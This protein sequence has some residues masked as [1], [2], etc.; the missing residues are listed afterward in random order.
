MEAVYTFSK[1]I[2]LGADY[3]N[4]AYD[5]DT[6]LSR[7]QWEYETQK[8][9]KSLSRFDQPHSFL[10]RASYD[11]PGT[12]R[13]WTGKALNNWIVS[14]VWLVRNG[15][16]FAVTTFDG[17]GYGN[18]DGNG[19]DRPNLLN[20]SI[21]GRT[22]GNPDTSVGLLPASAFT[23]MAPTDHGGN[24]GFNTFRRGGIR[25]LNAAIARTWPLWSE[26]RLTFRAESINLTNTPQFAEPGSILG[27]PE[28]GT[29][30]NTLNDGR[31][32]RL[33]LTAS[34]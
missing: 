9:R 34:W 10:L 4:T 7:S 31:T 8:D 26:A 2:D 29:I 17:P 19:N 18:V 6:R 23:F 27:S 15:T 13:G 24:L 25:N 1:A 28:F 5:A 12:Y 30:T 32:F 14:G 33:N 22:I 3:T 21:L 11:V 20:T 16:P